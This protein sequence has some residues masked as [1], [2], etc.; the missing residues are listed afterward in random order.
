MTIYSI[1]IQSPFAR[2]GKSSFNAYHKLYNRNSG[3]LKMGI[4]AR[5]INLP[6]VASGNPVKA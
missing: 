2:R 5:T 3:Q 6:N 4:S 1:T